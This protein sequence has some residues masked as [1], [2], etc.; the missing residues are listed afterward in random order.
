MRSERYNSLNEAFAAIAECT[1]V[2]SEI[3]EEY[4][5]AAIR[6]EVESGELL[7]AADAKRPKSKV[8]DKIFIEKEV[9]TIAIESLFDDL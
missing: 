4:E 8:S 1:C 6:L 3:R 5:K 2:P 9:R 7:A